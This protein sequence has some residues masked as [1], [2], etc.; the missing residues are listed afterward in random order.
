[1]KAYDNVTI[2]EQDERG[3]REKATQKAIEE[4]ETMA[5][6]KMYKDNVPSN[7]IAIYLNLSENRVMQI[8][9]SQND[10]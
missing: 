5:V 2:K 6:I 10:K 4:R 1:L 3:E 8:I 9:D 7:K